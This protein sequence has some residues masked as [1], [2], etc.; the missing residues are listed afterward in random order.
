MG[1]EELVE[2]AKQTALVGTDGFMVGGST[3][4]SLEKV[5]LA[6]EAIKDTTHL[7]VILFQ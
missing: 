3:D 7:P 1:S 6:V 5:D 2:L 4:L